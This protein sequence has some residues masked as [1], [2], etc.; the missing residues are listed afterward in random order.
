MKRTLSRKIGFMRLLGGVVVS[1][2]PRFTVYRNAGA[3]AA[4]VRNDANETG[5]VSFVWAPYVLRISVCKH[6]SQVGKSVVVFDPVK[7]VY[8]PFRPCPGHVQPNQTMRFVNAAAQAYKNVAFV[9]RRACH[10]AYM[11]GLSYAFCPSKKTSGGVV[12]QYATNV[13]CGK[14]GN[15]HAVAPV[16]QWFGKWVRGAATPYTGVYVNLKI[17]GLQA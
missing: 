16:K 5:L 13:V 12:I 10:I 17:T 8:Q 6:H 11:H 1:Y 4:L 14:I 9:V 2:A 15:V 3:P 7:V